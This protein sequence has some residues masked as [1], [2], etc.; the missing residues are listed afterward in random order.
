MHLYNWIGCTVNGIQSLNLAQSLPVI[1]WYQNNNK[2]F[3]KYFPNRK[4]K[5]K[6]EEKICVVQLSDRN[7]IEYFLRKCFYANARKIP[8]AN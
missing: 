7:K 1:I 4:K 3:R 5:K 8:F 6:K 2:I